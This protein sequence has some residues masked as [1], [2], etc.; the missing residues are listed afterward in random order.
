VHSL[1]EHV[2]EARVAARGIV[3]DPE[4][5]ILLVMFRSP[6][7]GETWWA[8]P[9]GGLDAGEPHEEG[10]RRELLEEAGIRVDE[11]GPCVWVREHV[12]E[13]GGRL[14][15]QTE[16]YFLVRVD[17]TEI[18][19]QLTAEQLASQG[20]HEVRWWSLRELDEADETFA[21]SRLPALLREL[22]EQ[23]PP[24][25]PIDAGV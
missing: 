8:T 7:T 15:R 6:E 2:P 20:L 13:W 19:P 16:R 4:D 22:L 17:S 3:L 18:A 5:R 25:E 11:I 10:L 23:G 21:P 24:A 14:L 9:G 12:F 1:A